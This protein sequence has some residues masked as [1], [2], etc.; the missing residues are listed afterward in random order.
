[1]PVLVNTAVTR[2]GEHDLIAAGLKEG[3]QVVTVRVGRKGAR[4]A[5]ASVGYSYGCVSDDGTGAVTNNTRNV[6]QRGILRMK[7]QAR[8][9]EGEGEMTAGEEPD[10]GAW[11]VRCC[12]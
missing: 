11:H 2:S 4:C 10:A 6:A 7:T 5:C 12:S 8:G 3:G 1:M 9:G